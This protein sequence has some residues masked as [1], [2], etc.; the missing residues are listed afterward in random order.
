MSIANDRLLKA[1][2]ADDAVGVGLAVLSGADVNC[3]HGANLT[4]LHLSVMRQCEEVAG[5]LVAAGADVNVKGSDTG[6]TP[7]QIA[8]ERG[9]PKLVKMMIAAGADIHQ[10]N[11]YARD[12]R[13]LLSSLIESASPSV[14]PIVEMRGQFTGEEL[15]TAVRAG[16]DD[17][18]E[19]MAPKVNNLEYRDRDLGA[20]AL[21]HAIKSGQKLVVR[22]LVHAGA[23]VNSPNR[24]GVTALHLASVCGDL[25]SMRLLR[26]HHA[27]ASLP[28][29]YGFTAMHGAS[30]AGH[31][32]AVEQLLE[33]GMDVNVRDSFG[34]TPLHRSA[35]LAMAKF[36]IE[37]GADVAA[38]NR[39]GE[40]ALHRAAM[41]GDVDLVNYL[42]ECGLNVNA[43]TVSGAA[44]LHGSSV[45]GMAAASEALVA[46][47]ADVSIQTSEGCTALHLAKDRRVIEIL[48]NAGAD[49]ALKDSNGKDSL[50][51]AIERKDI[52]STLYLLGKLNRSPLEEVMGQTLL[53][54]FQ[55][56]PEAKMAIKEAQRRWADSQAIA[57]FSGAVGIGEPAP[58][59]KS[60]GLGV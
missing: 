27:L 52:D 16:R 32:Q 55:A 29:A 8:C 31:V 37:S 25:D 43:Q 28:D 41:R 24:Y 15:L 51:L 14:E 13:S 6:V 10:E 60:V 21:H 47:G 2:L 45:M 5:V 12:S 3:A 35:D 54:H 59:S 58:K 17:L 4:A 36:L 42:V 57:A 26:E 34:N 19:C 22:A 30:R 39:F 9:S 7:Y 49:P 56:H 48:V 44:P 20:T 38:T 46:K 33:W 18:V 53:K 1:T 11:A 50:D 23:D 40:S